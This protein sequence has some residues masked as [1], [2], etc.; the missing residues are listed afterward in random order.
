[1]PIYGQ[2]KFYEPS[3]KPSPP[4]VP[5]YK[6]SVRKGV[7][8]IRAYRGFINASDLKNRR[9]PYEPT[10]PATVLQK[11]PV[12]KH[13]KKVK[14]AEPPR[15]RT[16]ILDPYRRRSPKVDDPLSEV[17]RR[18]SI[19]PTPRPQ[20]TPLKLQTPPVYQSKFSPIP[21]PEPKPIYAAA[22][23]P[24]KKASPKPKSKREVYS[25]FLYRS[26]TPFKKE[27]PQHKPKYT[28]SY[29]SDREPFFSPMIPVTTPEKG[30][31]QMMLIKQPDPPR[32]RRPSYPMIPVSPP[33]RWN[34]RRQDLYSPPSTPTSPG[35]D[36]SYSYSDY[37]YM[38]GIPAYSAVG[39]TLRSMQVYGR[40][41]R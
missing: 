22:A 37:S 14:A 11:T 6:G 39:A 27:A 16:P 19:E 33:P 15:V 20:P 32:G 38:P 31:Q 28:N 18:D 4:T 40:G 24:P 7:Y 30:T 12:P 23:P 35:P 36:W 1:M 5:P 3:I 17:H 21:P 8:K 9:K 34:T 2:P 10:I 41:P 13:I 29:K 25:P 26:P